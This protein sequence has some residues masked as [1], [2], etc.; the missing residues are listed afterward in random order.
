MSN[1]H[2]RIGWGVAIALS[3]L[4]ASACSSDRDLFVGK[5]CASGFCDDNT[6]FVSSDAG[7]DGDASTAPATEVQMCAVTT[8]TPPRTT[9]PNSAFPCDVDLLNDNENCGGCGVQCGT[10]FDSNWRCVEGKCQFACGNA[11]YSTDVQ[12]ADCDNDPTNGCEANTLLDANNCGQ[13]GFICAEGKMCYLGQC[14]S[15]CDL[16]GQPDE[17]GLFNCTN[18]NYDDANCGACG[19][20]CD[21]TGPDLAA[22]PNDMHYGCGGR[23]CGVSKCN[24]KNF[25]NCNGDKSD[26]CETQVHTTENCGGCGDKCAPGKE[27][28][29]GN[30]NL[31][32][33]TC[34]DDSETLCGSRCQSLT[35]DP[36]NCG[37]C[38][39]LCPGAYASHFVATCSNGVCGGEC[40]AGYADCN[41]LPDDGCEVDVRIDSRHCGACG[42][43]CSPGQVCADGKCLVE[44]CE[45]APETT[46]K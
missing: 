12:G 19:N 3:T 41:G 27:C 25:A 42:N 7:T 39:N 44:P 6:T 13:C 38:N 29:V 1:T 17:C 40:E 26:G 20:A 46:T 18:T 21:P 10:S 5:D 11:S 35:Q 28:L 2:S 23:Q 33:C 45:S 36:Y 4:A 31:Y 32:H 30:D 8:C 37:A 24:D 34:E 16:L 22:L 43:T 14:Y 15:L 9:C